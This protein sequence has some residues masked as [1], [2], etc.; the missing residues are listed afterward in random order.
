MCATVVLFFLF[1]L[2][3]ASSRLCDFADTDDA[4]VVCSHPYLLVTA[5][6]LDRFFLEL[7]A[8]VLGWAEIVAQRLTVPTQ[9]CR[10]V[11]RAVAEF[12]PP[13]ASSTTVRVKQ[14][15]LLPQDVCIFSLT[16][17]TFCFFVFL[18]PM[19]P[20]PCVMAT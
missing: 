4:L 11:Q 19:H 18:N 5:H 13:P 6:F 10:V 15:P 17:G 1:F 20:H 3:P 9:A 2:S 14:E 7:H 16:F 12:A 8:W